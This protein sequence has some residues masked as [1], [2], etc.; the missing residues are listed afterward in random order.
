LNSV[1][2]SF[3][4]SGPQHQIK[5]YR[6]HLHEKTGKPALT[7]GITMGARLNYPISRNFGCTVGGSIS[8]FTLSRKIDNRYIDKYTYL[9]TFH[10]T[11][12]HG[13]PVIMP[14][15]TYTTSVSARYS[16]AYHFTTINFPVSVY[17]IHDKWRLEGGIIPSLIISSDKINNIPVFDPA[18]ISTSYY[19]P[20]K[21]S[22]RSTLGIS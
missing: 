6:E 12:I 9:D 11:D 7:A 15:G 17:F 8:Y 10:T 5:G 14:A 20:F 18:E 19:F 3:N 16:E 21:N 2:V 13:N 1:M 22:R 4:D